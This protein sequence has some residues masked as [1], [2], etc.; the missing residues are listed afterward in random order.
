[1]LAIAELEFLTPGE[2]FRDIHMDVLRR[3]EIDQ[4]DG[5]EHRMRGGKADHQP[6]A[7]FLV[8]GAC[9]EP[10]RQSPD[11][12]GRAFVHFCGQYLST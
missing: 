4:D 7:G 2:G 1:M 5:P 10:R 12:R 3:L 6:T 9:G 11:H 8:A